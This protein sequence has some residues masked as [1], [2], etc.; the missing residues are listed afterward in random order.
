MPNHVMHRLVVK[1]PPAAL[2]AFT[3]KAFVER[4]GGHPR[5][6]FPEFDFNAFVPMPACLEGTVVATKLEPE[7]A[8]RNQVALEQTGYAT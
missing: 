7:Q 6:P 3:S 5:A 4:A 1:G 2:A 8:R